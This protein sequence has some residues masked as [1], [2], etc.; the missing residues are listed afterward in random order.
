V[1]RW[2]Q[3]MLTLALLS[4]EFACEPQRR[5]VVPQ[6]HHRLQR[7]SFV[8]VERPVDCALVQQQVCHLAACALKHRIWQRGASGCVQRCQEEA[9]L[10]CG[11]AEVADARVHAVRI[12]R[13]PRGGGRAAVDVHSAVV[14]TSD[15][16]PCW[17]QDLNVCGG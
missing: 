7:C 15:D 14:C 16:L 3:E 1:W 10:H 17:H 2:V 13:A 6:L 5:R 9:A 12:V 8:G 4:K 11:C